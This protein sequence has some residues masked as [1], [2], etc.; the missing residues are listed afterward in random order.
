MKEK[1]NLLSEEFEQF[2]QE[3][4]EALLSLDKYKILNYMAKYNIEVPDNEIIFWSGVHKAIVAIKYISNEHK[5]KSIKW[6][7][8][9]KINIIL[10]LNNKNSEGE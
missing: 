5:E 3:R 7:E 8:D 10:N 4:N 1:E 6:L 9:N 2:I